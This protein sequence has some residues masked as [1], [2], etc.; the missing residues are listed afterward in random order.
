[1]RILAALVLCALSV[2]AAPS[3]QP[4]TQA[5]LAQK[6]DALAAK[7]ADRF[8]AAKMTCI[9]AP[10][11][12]VAGDA[13]PPRVQRYVDHTIRSAAK[14]LERKYFDHASPTEPVL[15]LLF[16]SGEPYHR[17]AKEWLGDESI[18]RFGYFRRDNI[19]LMNVGTGTGT[20]VHELTHALLRPDFPQCPHWLNEGMGSLFEQCSLADNDIRGLEN[21]RLPGLQS[22]IRYKRLRA[23]TDLI[24]DPHFYD[25]EH[26]AMN[27]AQARYLLMFLQES[28]KLPGFY[29]NFRLNRDDDP[30]GL[31]QLKEAIA[32]QS[33]EQFE[34]D[35]RKWVMGLRF[36]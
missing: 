18:S 26:I 13:P 8:T 24:G 9:V 35:W 1:M 30:S 23:L 15:I 21:W 16:E 7:W 5:A 34:K 2:A 11:F 4:A 25:E 29:A 17:L 12:V 3:S 28:G 19:M 32:P 10:P 22:A 14:A 33:I 20:L 27:Y 36:N 6:C 31:K